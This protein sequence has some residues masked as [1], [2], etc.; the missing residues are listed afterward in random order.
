MDW[1]SAL[2]L[3]STVRRWVRS[4]GSTDAFS[5]ISYQVAWGRKDNDPQRCL[6]KSSKTSDYITQQEE[7]KDMNR[8]KVVYQLILRQ[9]GNSGLL[10]SIVT[11]P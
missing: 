1:G 5:L 10:T 6:V 7:I 4:Y 11:A 8:S 9:G 3:L 2:C